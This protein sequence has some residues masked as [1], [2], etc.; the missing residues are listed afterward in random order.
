MLISLERREGLPLSLEG[1]LNWPEYLSRADGGRVV[2]GATGG[3]RGGRLPSEWRRGQCP[4]V[5]VGFPGFAVIME[6]SLGGISSDIVLTESAENGIFQRFLVDRRYLKRAQNESAK[7]A[8]PGV[9]PTIKREGG[10]GWR[11]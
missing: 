5:E 7:L 10:G 9:K 8:Q 2:G 6:V 3:V 1:T 4:G 11:S